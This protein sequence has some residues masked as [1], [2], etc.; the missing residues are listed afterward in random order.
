M[1]LR[2]C[3]ELIE[4]A[5][6]L[7]F[8]EAAE[9][10]YLT[11]SALSKHV[12]AAEREVGFRI[13]ERDTARVGLTPAGAALVDGLRT[14]VASYDEA[15]ASAL[16]TLH[17][18]AAA[19]RVAGPFLNDRIIGIVNEARVACLEDGVDVQLSLRDI[20]VRDGFD[21]L[22]EHAADIVLGFC[23]GRPGMLGPARRLR[24]EHLFDIP[25]GIA[26]YDDHPL[27]HR[28]PLHF[29]DVRGQRLYS[30]PTNGREMYH[31]YVAQVCR[32]HR[33][34]SPV[35]HCEDGLLCAPSAPDQLVFGVYFPGFTRVGANVVSRPLD[36]DCDAFPLYAA[37]LKR[38][39]APEA[40]LLFE[41]VVRLARGEGLSEGDRTSPGRGNRVR[42]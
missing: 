13:F 37:C 9:R 35:E 36:E 14:V 16:E 21:A 38:G 34:V 23:Y 8:S 26:C 19:V 1:D 11:Q 31:E 5:D 29:A 41:H 42:A 17:P 7:N 28:H 2:C 4:L 3:R 6:R 30:Y 22:P 25:F 24:M 18:R 10:L 32:K 33:I 40:V 27:A 15:L 12:A 20:G 39:A